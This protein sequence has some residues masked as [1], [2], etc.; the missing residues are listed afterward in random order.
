MGACT[1]F[2]AHG[3]LT[4]TIPSLILGFLFGYSMKMSGL[5]I[6]NKSQKKAI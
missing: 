1:I 2:A 5:W 3:H 6:A 4:Q